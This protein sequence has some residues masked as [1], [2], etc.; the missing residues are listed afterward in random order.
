MEL[1]SRDDYLAILADKFSD[2]DYDLFVNQTILKDRVLLKL[3][4]IAFSPPVEVGIHK[5]PLH[6]KIKAAEALTDS[7]WRYFY[8]A[9]FLTDDGTLK[10]CF[11]F[12]KERLDLTISLL[13]ILSPTT[14]SLTSEQFDYSI[15]QLSIHK[16]SKFSDGRISIDIGKYWPIFSLKYWYIFKQQIL[17]KQECQIHWL[18]NPP[19]RESIDKDFLDWE[20]HAIGQYVKLHDIPEYETILFNADGDCD[21]LIKHFYKGKPLQG[22][23]DKA[24]HFSLAQKYKKLIDGKVE[25]AVK[26]RLI[27][28]QD[29]YLDIELFEKDKRAFKYILFENFK[30]LITNW[31]TQ[32]PTNIPAQYFEKNMRGFITK[33]FRS[34]EHT[35]TQVTL[36]CYPDNEEDWYNCKKKKPK[37]INNPTCI[38]RVGVKCGNSEKRRTLHS[39]LLTNPRDK[40]ALQKS[41]DRENHIDCDPFVQETIKEI[42]SDKIDE[43]I[44]SL[45]IDDKNNSEIGRQLGFSEGGVRK[46]I[47][48]IREI[49]KN[50]YPDILKKYGIK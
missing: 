16:I 31:E 8:R 21:F 37:D 29:T 28:A 1:V 24:M 44:I 7:D 12:L 6:K 38:H 10:A 13:K 9:Y 42:S 35:T 34:K 15:S 25:D 39:E 17:I 41:D 50:N 26:K 45:M 14:E 5:Y 11:K 20:K 27:D 47:K 23:R 32:R 4:N 36:W 3:H 30:S 2:D 19:D 18:I 46:R 43:E 33:L 48:K 40:E 22:N 49:F